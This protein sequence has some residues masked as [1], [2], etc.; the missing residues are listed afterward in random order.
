MRTIKDL[1]A[2][3]KVITELKSFAD[4]WLEYFRKK[5]SIDVSSIVPLTD[6]DYEFASIDKSK[7]ALFACMFIKRFFER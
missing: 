3:V 5:Y 4:E 1:N 2:E 7:Q 6:K